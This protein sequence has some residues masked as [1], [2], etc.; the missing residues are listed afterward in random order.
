MY[1]QVEDE[2]K[3]F[4]IL[5]MHWGKRKAESAA[6]T[7]A[8]NSLSEQKLKAKQVAI[9]FDKE[10]AGGR[11]SPSD[12]TLKRVMESR[13][14]LKTSKENLSSVKKQAK[15]KTIDSKKVA[16][17]KSIVIGMLAGTLGTITVAAFSK[18]VGASP[19]SV[20]GIGVGS[21]VGIGLGKAYYDH[22]QKA[23]T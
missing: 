18:K 10:T 20:M 12:K 23:N 8:R 7:K 11:I 5:G 17:G 4:G 13:Q 21:G 14:G 1:G 9:A 22:N 19:F 16:V 6:V 15:L 2:I 3:H